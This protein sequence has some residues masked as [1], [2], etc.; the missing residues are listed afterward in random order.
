[1]NIE[2]NTSVLLEQCKVEGAH[3]EDQVNFR[4]HIQAAINTT[5]EQTAIHNENGLPV[6]QCKNHDVS[7]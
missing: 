2:T 6:P 4:V 1:M 3:V 5:S 7:I